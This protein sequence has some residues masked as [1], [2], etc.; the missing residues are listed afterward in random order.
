MSDRGFVGGL[1]TTAYNL[2]SIKRQSLHSE[3]VQSGPDIL[4]WNPLDK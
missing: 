1:L 4:D 2:P 3:H